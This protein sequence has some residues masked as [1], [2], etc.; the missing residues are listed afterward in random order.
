MLLLHPIKSL[1][2]P[3]QT[4]DEQKGEALR[5]NF[6]YN[7]IE[8]SVPLKIVTSFQRNQNMVQTLTRNI[9]WTSKSCLENVASFQQNQS[10]VQTLVRYTGWVC[11]TSSHRCPHHYNP[12]SNVVTLKRLPKAHVVRQHT[13]SPLEQPVSAQCWSWTCHTKSRKIDR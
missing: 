6:F 8:S 9:R 1:R 4:D 3:Q 10:I 2:C 13:A 7:L 12:T 5:G 11:K